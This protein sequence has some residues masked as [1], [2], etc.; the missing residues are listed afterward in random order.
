SSDKAASRRFP[1]DL[2]KLS[3][4]VRGIDLLAKGSL[5]V[6]T[7]P[8]SSKYTPITS[9]MRHNSVACRALNAMFE[10]FPNVSR[11]MILPRHSVVQAKDPPCDEWTRGESAA[12]G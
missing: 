9:G 10:K 1:A 5:W 6:T 3:R 11:G 4:S 12:N 7:Y 8:L 2:I